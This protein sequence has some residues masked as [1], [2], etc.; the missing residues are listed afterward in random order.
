MKD[1]DKKPN[2][3]NKTDK[4]NKPNNIFGAIGSA[5][6]AGMKAANEA[7]DN[8]IK[9][10]DQDG[11]G[12]IDSTDIII[13]ALKVPGVKI[14]RE[15]FLRKELQ[16]YCTPETIQKAIDTTPVVRAIM[17]ILSRDALAPRSS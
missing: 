5:G 7:K 6:T 3:P 1:K 15:E 14:P 11:N 12:I 10:I 9:A 2:E 17:R 8:L 16:R 4:E 13:M